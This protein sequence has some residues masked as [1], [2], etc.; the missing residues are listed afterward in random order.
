[1]TYFPDLSP[2]TYF[3]PPGVSDPA[4]NV[5]WLSIREPFPQGEVP[6]G[7]V[8]RLEQHCS[9]EPVN[10]TFGMHQCEFCVA[11]REGTAPYRATTS[12]VACGSGEIRV[13]GPGGHI[14]AAPQLILHYVVEH[15]Y[16]PPGEFIDAMMAG[17][18][19][20][21]P[22]Y[23]AAM[24]EHHERWEAWR[25]SHP[26][27]Q[28]VVTVPES[29]VRWFDRI[30]LALLCVLT[31]AGAIIAIRK[32]LVALPFLGAGVAHA[33]ASCRNAFMR[34]D[35]ESAVGWALFLV[36]LFA[37]SFAILRRYG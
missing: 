28:V 12:D 15:H 5:G 6:P 35:Y 4:L 9:A 31:I 36:L 21:T 16:C 3:C 22:P 10:L 29:Q 8:E 19:P 33:V 26:A 32:P 13:I 7:F 25:Q 23:Q 24:G 14:Y 11:T 20:G 34:R 30:G 2:Y 37:V 18:L 27:P 1:M 17:P